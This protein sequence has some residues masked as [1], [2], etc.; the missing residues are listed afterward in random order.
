MASDSGHIQAESDPLF[1]TPTEND[2]AYSLI[3]DDI[4]QMKYNLRQNYPNPFNPSTTISFLIPEAEY[5]KLDIYNM[6]GMKIHT[7]VSK[8]LNQGNYQ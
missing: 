6:L 2:D 7:L 1:A 4:Y 5:V 8:Y 3:D